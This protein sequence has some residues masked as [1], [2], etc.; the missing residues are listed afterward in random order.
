MCRRYLNR[1]TDVH[2]VRHVSHALLRLRL[3]LRLRLLQR[4]LFKHRSLLPKTI[5]TCPNTIT[6]VQVLRGMYETRLDGVWYTA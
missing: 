4:L 5:L 3:R 2:V 6:D 1:A